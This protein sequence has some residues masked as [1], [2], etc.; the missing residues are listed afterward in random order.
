MDTNSLQWSTAASLPSGLKL[1]SATV[2]NGRIYLLGGKTSGGTSSTAAF[3]CSL[4][5]LLQS[6]HSQLPSPD[7]G[8]TTETSDIPKQI[9]D[10]DDNVWSIIANLPLAD[11]TCVSLSG[12]LLAIGGR[13][14]GEGGSCSTA[15]NLYTL[16]VWTPVA[17]RTRS[18]LRNSNKPPDLE[19]VV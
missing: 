4:A 14:L 9:S 17:T 2:C 8:G 10:D 7:S 12:Q 13:S 3:V 1:S 18:R 5:D 19:V 11:C 15:V 6:S 16:E